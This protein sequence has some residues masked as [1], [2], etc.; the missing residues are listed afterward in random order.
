MEPNW[1][2]VV[3]PLLAVAMAFLI[4]D[5]AISLAVACLAGVL[6]LGEG[7]MGFPALITRSLST[8]R[9]V[10]LCTLE[11]AIGI[12]ID[13]FQRCGAIAMFTRGTQRWVKNRKQVSVLGWGMGMF[14]FF[15]DYFSTLLV[16]PVMRNL[17]D[18][19]RILREKLA[20]IC[21]STS[22]PWWPSCPSRAGRFIRAGWPSDMPE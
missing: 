5:A 14:I 8:E 22:A 7:L 15:S 16:G 10:W 6:I 3:P 13:F 17:T 2:S 12:F 4:R 19:Y 11:F 9:F 20:Y 18:K 1:T 21:D